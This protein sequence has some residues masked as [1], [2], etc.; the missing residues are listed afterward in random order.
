MRDKNRDWNDGAED[1]DA[2]EQ[3]D[4]PGTSAS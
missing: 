4:G 3:P 1:K 2:S